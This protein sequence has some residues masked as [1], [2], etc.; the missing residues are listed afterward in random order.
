MADFVRDSPEQI[1][2]AKRAKAAELMQQI[3]LHQSTSYNLTPVQSL[4]DYL[5]GCFRS[6]VT[7]SVSVLAKTKACIW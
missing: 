5:E 7:P 2:Y 1:N 6:E 4:V 3:E